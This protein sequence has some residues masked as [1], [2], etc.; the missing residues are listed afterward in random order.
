MNANTP[1]VRYYQLQRRLPGIQGDNGCLADVA[2]VLAGS[3]EA[4]LLAEATKHSDHMLDSE[5]RVAPEPVWEF[6]WPKVE[7]TY[8]RKVT[9]G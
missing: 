6:F 5:W 3:A 4:A 9:L 7:T 1:H 8:S 2:V